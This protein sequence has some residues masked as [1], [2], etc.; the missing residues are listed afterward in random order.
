MAWTDDRI[1]DA[2]DGLRAEMREMRTDMREMRTEMTDGF[3]DV[4]HDILGLQRQL[5]MIGWGIAAALLGQFIA[6]IVALVV[7]QS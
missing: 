5:T 1:G 6:L 2:V 3:R 4:R 7:T